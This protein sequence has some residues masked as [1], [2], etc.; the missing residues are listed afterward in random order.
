LART[1]ALFEK[2]RKNSFCRCK[3]HRSIRFCPENFGT[4]A[5]QWGGAR[6]RRERKRKGSL[7]VSGSKE[8][9]VGGKERGKGVEE[10][11]NL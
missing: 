2:A 3:K 9:G 5:Q 1:L 10:E 4:E 8:G 6:K 11:N 7:S